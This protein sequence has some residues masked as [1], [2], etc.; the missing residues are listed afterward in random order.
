MAG[1]QPT[2]ITGKR[3]G[4]LVAIKLDHIERTKTGTVHYWLYRCDCG[5]EKV[6]RKG[7]VSQGGSQS[8]GC[9]L[10]ES[11]GNRNRT[12]GGTNTRLYHTYKDMKRRCYN[13]KFKAYKDY[14]GRGITI[15]QEWL[16]DFLNFKKWSLESGYKDNLTIERID[17]NGNYE[18]GNCKWIPLKEQTYNTRKNIFIYVNNEKH[19]IKEWAEILNIKYSK[20]IYHI[21]KNKNY[22]SELVNKY[23]RNETL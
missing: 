1:R 4:K 21:K 7:E 3:Y 20:L 23:E 14:G 6:I 12:H 13:P 22:I 17:F 5:N 2:D 8:C 16:S 9:Y 10:K 18:P 15:C 11:A 19:C